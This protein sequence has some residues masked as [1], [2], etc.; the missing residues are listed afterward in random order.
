[1]LAARHL[2]AS[3]QRQAINAL[4]FLYREVMETP[5]EW[6]QQLD[7]PRQAKHLPHVLSIDQVGRVL[8]QMNGT[9]QLMTQLIY[10]SGLRISECMSLRLKDLLWSFNTRHVH[11]GKGGQGPHDGAAPAA[12]QAGPRLRTDAGC[13]GREVRRGRRPAPLAVPVSVAGGTL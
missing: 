11:G 7:R 8:R 6:L 2:S 5:H 13:P 4:D 10:G 3:S 1:M 12:A 9:E